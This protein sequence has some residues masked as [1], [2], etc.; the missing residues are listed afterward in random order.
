M[1]DL[2]NTRLFGGDKI[3]VEPTRKNSGGGRD[4][5]RGDRDRH[6]RGDPRDDRRRRSPSATD[7][8]FNCGK[9]GHW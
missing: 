7:K 9:T 5:R 6:D 1:K 8:C 3:T 4:E 2:D